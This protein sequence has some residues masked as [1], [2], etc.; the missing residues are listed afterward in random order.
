M[1]HWH[2]KAVKFLVEEKVAS[3][4]AESHVRATEG[5]EAGEPS[6][7]WRTGKGRMKQGGA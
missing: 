4:L 6:T 5:T 3:T 1:F 2:K 7:G